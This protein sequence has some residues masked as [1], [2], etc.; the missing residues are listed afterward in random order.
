[1][2]KNRILIF[3]RL[4]KSGKKEVVGMGWT[5]EENFR[6]GNVVVKI[7]LNE[8]VS[9]PKMF[10]VIKNFNEEITISGSA[11]SVFTKLNN[12]LGGIAKAWDIAQA[13]TMLHDDKTY[14]RE[15]KRTQDLIHLILQNLSLAG[16]NEEHTDRNQPSHTDE[17]KPSTSS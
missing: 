10:V 9:P 7:K 17:S 8:Q 16:I 3:K 1:M 12:L 5:Y 14:L 4:K 6:L 13:F 11:P 2:E 15:I